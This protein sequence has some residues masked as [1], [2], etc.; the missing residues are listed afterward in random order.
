MRE[1]SNGNIRI[2]TGFY[3]WNFDDLKS[4][5][6]KIKHHKIFIHSMLEL[7]NETLDILYDLQNSL[8]YPWVKKEVVVAH[9]QQYKELS[10]ACNYLKN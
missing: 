2:G 1:R 10:A 8:A 4:G 5:E 9:I 6:F 7:P 3:N